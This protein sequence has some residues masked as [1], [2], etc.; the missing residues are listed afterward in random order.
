M[1]KKKK[2]AYT[3]RIRQHYP[4]AITT[5]R[6]V[7]RLFRIL[8]DDLGLKPSQVVLADSICSDDVN[9]IEYPKA[10]FRMLGPFKLGGLDGFPFTGRTGMHAFAS[11][12]PRNGAALIYHAPHIGISE[13]G[14][15]GRIKREGQHRLSACCGACDAAIDTL[16]KPQRRPADDLDH[17]QDTLKRILRKERARIVRSVSPIKEATEVLYDAITE[18]IDTLWS[19]EPFPT[20][21]VILV[22]GILI[23]TDAKTCSFTD[24]RRAEVID[25]KKGRRTDIL[26]RLVRSQ[27]RSTP[28]TT[29]SK[30][31]AQERKERRSSRPRRR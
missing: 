11:H 20:R 22:G 18:R 29:P 14:V 2:K 17:Q 13:S 24:I 30:P 27:R 3:E 23:N 10:A 26:H 7:R 4:E 5:E 12:G 21:Y 16:T 1:G 9:S 28:V 31:R 15:V 8:K 25:L 6:V 19:H